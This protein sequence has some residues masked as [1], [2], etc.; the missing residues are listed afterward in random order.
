MAFES[1]PPLQGWVP[2]LAV[3]EG[4]LVAWLLM[5]YGVTLVIT[6][7]RIM[8][9]LRRLI[10]RNE[11]MRHFIECPMC[12]GW[13]AAVGISCLGVGPSHCVPWHPGLRVIADGF[14]GSA[15]CWMVHVALAKLGAEQL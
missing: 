14:C 4:P 3:T 6:G 10:G 7:S 12:I 2:T 1:G 13:W 11:W 9:P 8:A 15:W 5:T